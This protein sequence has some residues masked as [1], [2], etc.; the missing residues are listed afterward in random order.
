MSLHSSWSP[1][2]AQ[3]LARAC[4]YAGGATAWND[5]QTIRLHPVENGLTGLVPRLKGLGRTFVMPEYFDVMPHQRCAR[6]VGYPAPNSVGIFENGAVRIEGPAGVSSRSEL[7]RR[8][9]RGLS[10]YRRWSALDALY[11]FGYALTHYH[12]LPFTLREATLKSSYRE[13]GRGR[14]LDVLEVE[15]PED[16]PSHCRQQRFY[17]SEAGQLVRND[18][19]AEIL[20]FWARGAHYWRESTRVNGLTV[21]LERYVLARVGRLTLPLVALHARFARAELIPG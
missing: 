3:V 4:E 2:A 5:A 15:L 18:Y 17:F 8:S 12:A 16:V 21:C 13:R 7:H 14:T 11:F 19:H 6:F 10:K 20:G 1:D 9:F